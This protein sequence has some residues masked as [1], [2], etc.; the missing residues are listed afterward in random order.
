M[1]ETIPKGVIHMEGYEVLD[2]DE[3]VKKPYSFKIIK[4]GFR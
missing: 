1:K 2:A 4:D 3:D